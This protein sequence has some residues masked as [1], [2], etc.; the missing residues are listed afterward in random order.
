MRRALVVATALA[1]AGCGREQAA[2]VDSTARKD[3]APA[4]AAPAGP[5]VAPDAY[6][7]HV[8]S[9]LR[10]GETRFVMRRIDP[11]E[12]ELIDTWRVEGVYA[13]DSLVFTRGNV[14]ADSFATLQFY[15]RGD[16]VVRA[17]VVDADDAPPGV[18]STRKGTARYYFEGDS[19]VA[20]EGTGSRGDASRLLS[21][22]AALRAQLARPGRR[23]DEQRDTLTARPT[24]PHVVHG[25]C[26]FECCHYGDWTVHNDVA[27]R[28]TYAPNAPVV[29]KVA[30]N[31]VVRADSGLVIL[32]TIG[33]VAV[34]ATVTDADGGWDFARGDTI[35]VLDYQGEGYYEAWLRGHAISVTSF[36]NESGRS[37]ARMLRPPHQMWWTHFTA[38]ARGDTVRGWVHMNDTLRVSGADACGG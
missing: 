14:P 2:A 37:G 13:G 26:P 24:V 1:A 36:W 11:K 31:T 8:D 28:A 18:P 27:L 32:D 4:I 21:S 33:L 9:L 5:Q 35:L 30:S 20:V 29:G 25:A 19:V 15:L 38:A 34:N 7:A 10:R 6:V 3:S 12:D 22:L 17:D 16:R 23:V